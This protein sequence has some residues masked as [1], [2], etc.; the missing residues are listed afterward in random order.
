MVHGVTINPVAFLV[1]NK[2]TIK[3][4]P[5]DHCST[6]DRIVDYVPDILGK[7]CECMKNKDKNEENCNEEEK[8]ENDIESK[9]EKVVIKSE[10]ENEDEYLEDE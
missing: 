3:L 8:T 1:I 5:I 7:V 9:A 6:L 4:M 10:M 2:E